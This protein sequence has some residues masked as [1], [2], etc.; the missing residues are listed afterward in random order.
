MVEGLLFVY[1][2]ACG[3]LAPLHA[4]RQLAR[5]KPSQCYCYGLPIPCKWGPCQEW[6]QHQ[7]TDSTPTHSCSSR[8]RNLPS[9]SAGV[10]RKCILCAE[11]QTERDTH[12]PASFLLLLGPAARLDVD[13]RLEIFFF[14]FSFFYNNATRRRET[15][16]EINYVV[17]KGL[18][19]LEVVNGEVMG[20]QVY[21]G[22]R[23]LGCMHVGRCGCAICL[24]VWFG[25]GLCRGGWGRSRFLLGVGRGRACLVRV[26]HRGHQAIS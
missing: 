22:L 3:V 6:E 16:I 17:E 26:D 5:P 13:W 15:T 1:G 12:P 19:M 20:L 21:D 23:R 2:C 10:G 7:R 8:G 4:Y 9:V 18:R 24:C 14:F 11:G 25:A